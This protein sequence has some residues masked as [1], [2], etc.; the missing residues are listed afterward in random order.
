MVAIRRV[1][2]GH[3]LLVVATCEAARAAYRNDDAV[4]TF[5]ELAAG[6]EPRAIEFGAQTMMMVRTPKGHPDVVH[7]RVAKNRRADRGE[8]WLRVDRDAHGVTEIGNPAEDP[9]AV[10]EAVRRDQRAA[11]DHVD[12]DARDMARVLRRFPTGI[13]ESNLRG[14]V[15]AEGLSWGRDR[16]GAARAALAEGVDGSRLVD[17]TPGKRGRTWTLRAAPGGD[18]C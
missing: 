6:A 14:A 8:L 3:R 16:F 7:V 9:A 1:A 12:R 15:K 10:A 13:T 4:D 18:P 5:N 2:S 11:R 17:L